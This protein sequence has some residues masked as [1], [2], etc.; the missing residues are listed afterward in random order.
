MQ[1]DDWKWS[2]KTWAHARMHKRHISLFLHVVLSL[3]IMTVSNRTGFCVS[4]LHRHSPIHNLID[5]LMRHWISSDR[6]TKRSTRKKKRKK[7]KKGEYKQDVSM[8]FSV[9]IVVTA[10]RWMFALSK[11]AF[12]GKRNNQIRSIQDFDHSFSAT[13]NWRTT[14]WCRTIRQNV[15]RKTT[16]RSTS[17]SFTRKFNDLPM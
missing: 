3:S 15:D 11:I 1:S 13:I 14:S 5:N 17:R 6:K 16:I 9:H 12:F 7:P 2:K 4:N 10:F 8:L